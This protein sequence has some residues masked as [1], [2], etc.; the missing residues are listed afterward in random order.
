MGTAASEHAIS[1]LMVD[2]HD[3][4]RRGIASTLGEIPDIRILG[5]A[6]SGE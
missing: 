4:V 6:A 2:D 3:I 1:V 5:E